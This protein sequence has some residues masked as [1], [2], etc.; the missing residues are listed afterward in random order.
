MKVVN[1]IIDDIRAK[2]GMDILREWATK[3]FQKKIGE[4]INREMIER[5]LEDE[6]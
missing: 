2:H 6:L 3:G 1:D 5:G 4:G